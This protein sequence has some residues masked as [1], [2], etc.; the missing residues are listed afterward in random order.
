MTTVIWFKD[1]RV[2]GHH[3]EPTVTAEPITWC[4]DCGED[5]CPHNARRV[6]RALVAPVDVVLRRGES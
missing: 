4:P 3:E 1:G 2:V 6:A 5:D